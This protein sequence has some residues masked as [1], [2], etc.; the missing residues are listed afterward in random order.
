MAWEAIAIL[1]SGLFAGAALY[2][3]LVEHPARVQCGTE[4]AVTEFGPSY[5]RATL[6]QVPLAV[7]GFVAGAI[8]WFSGNEL[9]WLVGAI[10]LGAVI[11]FTLL[12]IFPTNKKLLDPALDRKSP[13]A[14]ELLDRWGALHAVRSILSVA[15]F[16]LFVFLRFRL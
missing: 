14:R 2:I 6:L 9:G 8:S 10:A 3:N 15:A 13:L 1:A 4:L 16:I 11:P 12:V 5:H 7:V